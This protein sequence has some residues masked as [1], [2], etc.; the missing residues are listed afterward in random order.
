MYIHLW[1]G[2][3]G[4]GGGAEAPQV[5]ADGQLLAPLWPLNMVFTK[6][7]EGCTGG[8]EGREG[9]GGEWR[10]VE[11]RGVEWSGGEGSPS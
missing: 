4:G 3:G 2:G 9:R 8:R 5:Q 10:G 7:T 6:V 1:G 11:W